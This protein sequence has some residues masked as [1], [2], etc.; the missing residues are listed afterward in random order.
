VQTLPAGLEQ[1]LSG[2]ES[3]PG[4]ESD[5]PSSVRNMDNS[6][7]AGPKAVE[8]VLLRTSRVSVPTHPPLL[9]LPAIPAHAAVDISGISPVPQIISPGSDQRRLQRRRPLHVGP[10]E[11]PYL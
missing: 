7:D 1:T 6:V 2:D 9:V 8:E 4:A 11:P 3:S 5:A 10:S